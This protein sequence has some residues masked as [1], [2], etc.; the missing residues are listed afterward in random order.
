MLEGIY[1]YDENDAT[2]SKKSEG[3]Y[4]SLIGSDVSKLKIGVPKEFFGDGLNDE[5]KTA[6][7]NAVE[8]YKKLGCEVVDCFTS[9]S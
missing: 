5:V 8:Y 2:S 3:N 7:L 6:V 9:E 1:G 4:N